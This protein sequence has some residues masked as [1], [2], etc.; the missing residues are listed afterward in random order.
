VV[1]PTGAGK[2]FLSL[3][4]TAHLKRRTVVL[5]N[6]ISLLEQWVKRFK[7]HAGIEAGVWY[8]ERKDQ[9]L[10]TISTYQ[11]LY[12]HVEFIRDCPVVF[13]DEGDLA[14]ANHWGALVEEA[15]H[16]NH[17]YVVLLTATWPQNPEKSL[18]LQSL[19]PLLHEY[20]PHELRQVGAIVPIEHVRVEIPLNPTEKQ[21]YDGVSENLDEAVKLLKTNTVRQISAIAYAP[22]TAP[23]GR[24]RDEAQRRKN[25][26]YN[27][28]RLL[29]HRRRLLANA[30]AKFPALH[31]IIE[32]HKNEKVLV[33]SDLLTTL[34]TAKEYLAPHG[35]EMRLLTGETPK[36]ERGSLLETWGTEYLVL[37]AAKVVDRGLDV[38]DVGVLAIVGS[39]SSKIQITQRI[40]RAL[41]PSPGKERA[42]VYVVYCKDTSERRVYDAVRR[43]TAA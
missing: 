37:G 28:L 12:N 36:T 43:V 41:R 16:G 42:T 11:S 5:V 14:V 33:F 35:I 26:A 34:T 25:M 10:V 1:W 40:G 7:D 31:T 6:T 4:L 13:F 3:A 17:E 39:G 20:H 30:E 21:E 23:E 27:Y 29:S 8:G 38:P 24:E 18:A 2:S 15:S 9:R 22:I 32:K 19:L